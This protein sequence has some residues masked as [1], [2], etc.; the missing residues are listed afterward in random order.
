MPSKNFRL[1]IV[2]ACFTALL[3]LSDYEVKNDVEFSVGVLVGVLAWSR[4][5]QSCRYWTG[6]M[7]QTFT[8]VINTEVGSR[9]VS[10]GA[11]ANALLK[12]KEVCADAIGLSV[13]EGYRS[14]LPIPKPTKENPNE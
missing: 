12:S 3:A 7:Q 8:V 5:P 4:Q 6:E 13:T 14:Q 1:V 10:A 2:I 9:P 11:V